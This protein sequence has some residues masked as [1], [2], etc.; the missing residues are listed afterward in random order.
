[1][2]FRT[3]FEITESKEKISLSN[4][5]FTI[6][7]CFSEVIGN[8]MLENKI[9]V[10]ANSFG[11]LFNPLSIFK[12]LSPSYTQADERLF[13]Q[14][15]E[16]WF[17][18]DFHAKFSADTQE[19]LKQEINS[20]I[21]T[22]QSKI[23]NTDFLIITFGTA[24]IYQLKESPTYVANCHKMPSSLFEKSLLSVKDICKKFAFLHQ[25]LQ[26]QN[27]NLKI[28]LTVSPVRHTR[29]GMPENQVSK[30]ILRAAC[31]YLV[32]D[33]ENVSYFPSYEI[34][35]DDLRDYRFYKPDMIHPNEVAETYIF[36]KFS[37]TYFDQELQDFIPN[38]VKIRKS[39]AHKPFNSNTESHQKFLVN[40]L[41][42]LNNLSKK[43]NLDA[44]IEWVKN[45]ISS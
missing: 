30:S 44:E 9:N 37:Q 13:V 28:I 22:E 8:Q 16:R 36:E 27:P 31:H 45:V 1:M 10:S 19:D 3:S 43:V 14:S 21:Q 7:S 15:Q 34:M 40:L 12:I 32:S 42:Q 24:F 2:E 25:E 17:H 18:H 20:T 33:Y 26:V 35:L 6:G 39:L 38:W 11:A 4:Q 41:S 29:E 5:I 23:K